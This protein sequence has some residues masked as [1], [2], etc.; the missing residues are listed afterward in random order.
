MPRMLLS[1]I[2]L[3]SLFAPTSSWAQAIAQYD[4]IHFPTY[5]KTGMVASQ[6][7]LASE[8]G[9]AVLADGGNAVDASIAVGFALAVTLPRAGN[10]G[11][12]GFMLVH[13]AATGENI[14]IDFREIAPIGATRDMFLDENGDASPQL[15]RSSHLSAGVPG[16]VAG[17]YAA[18]QQFGSLPWKRLVQPAADIARDGII[19]TKDLSDVVTRY[20]ERLCAQP[21]SCAYFF[22]SDGSAYQMG[23]R[24]VQSDLAWSLQLIADEGPDAFYKGAIADKLVAEMKRGGGIVDYASLAG[25]RP[26]FK[27]ALVGHYRDHEIIAMPPSSSGGVHVI[28]ML[29]VLQHF[30]IG[31]MGFGS[32]DAIHVTA[33]A[34]Q[35]AYADRSEHLGDSDFYDVPLEWLMSDEYAESLANTIAMDRARPSAEVRPGVAPR[36]ESDDTT[37]ISVIDRDGNVVSLTYTL[38]TSFGSGISVAGAGF[39]LNN[40]MDD[41]VSKPGTPNVYGLLGNEANAIEAGKRPLSSM[42]PVILLKEGDVVMATGS[43]GGSRIITTV[44]QMIMNV[45]DHNMGLADAAH[46]PRIHHQWFPDMLFVE[47]GISPDTLAILT[48]RGHNVVKRNTL[49]TSLQTVGVEG[50]YFRGVSDPRRPGAGAAAPVTIDE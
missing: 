38:N 13:S 9:A 6:N 39:I 43:P 15:S 46:A 28:Q 29:N 8:I 50:E 35:M 41:F 19:V 5:S 4:R 1:T 20:R 45:V 26:V 16:T 32:A 25:Y 42:T 34:M 12:G 49:S 3:V 14:A 17:L 18:H 31:E 36:K 47:A 37:H 48:E 30:P 11:G 40:E 10:L 27:D 21:V 23:E 22:K 2:V 44:L 33:A 7:Q 24:L